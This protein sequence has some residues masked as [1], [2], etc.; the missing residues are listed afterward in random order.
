V[1]LLVGVVG[2]ARALF[3]RH[4]RAAAV[5]AACVVALIVA[6]LMSPGALTTR[7]AYSAAIGRYLAPVLAALALFAAHLGGRR[8]LPLWAAAAAVQLALAVPYSWSVADLHAIAEMLL[9][10]IPVLAALAIISLWARLRQR[11]R[12]ALAL[13]VASLAAFALPWHAARERHRY[14]IYEAAA[15]NASY[16]AHRLWPRYV[17]SYPIWA[18]F[19]GERPQR[20]AIAAGW[21]GFS[22]NW[23]RYPFFGSRL[24]NEIVYVTPTDDGSIVNYWRAGR[25]RKKASLRAWVARLLAADAGFLVTLPPEPIEG[26]LVRT[27]PQLFE[28]VAEGVGRFARAYRFRRDL[29]TPWLAQQPEAPDR[30]TSGP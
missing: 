19:D 26:E 24:Q 28:P 15:A 17:K 7:T 14:R 10:L 1:F 29:A 23:Y 27:A 3:R 9:S 4:T 13:G 11:P 12:L 5:F 30:R 8:T 21:D 22:T 18:Y 16:D 20:I 25:L 6:G 2:L